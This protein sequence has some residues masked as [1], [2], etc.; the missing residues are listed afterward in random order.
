MISEYEKY[1]LAFKNG[2]EQE[3]YIDEVIEKIGRELKFPD[4]IGNSRKAVASVIKQLLEQGI[5]KKEKSIEEFLQYDDF[6]EK[7]KIES[8]IRYD[9]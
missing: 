6:V 9:I 8:K 1:R 2:F 5:I 4:E 7:C 3:R